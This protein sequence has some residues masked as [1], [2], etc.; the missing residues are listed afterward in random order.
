MNSADT[1]KAIAPIV[2]SYFCLDIEAE[3]A[4]SAIGH[5]LKEARAATPA[6]NGRDIPSTPA[7]FS[8][9]D[10]DGSV[11]RYPAAATAEID[12]SERLLILGADNKIIA[13]FNR[14]AWAHVERIAA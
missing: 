11:S 1:I 3:A 8:I 5:A 12:D 6:T 13:M 10:H 7:G 9:F 14:G 4:M 2:R